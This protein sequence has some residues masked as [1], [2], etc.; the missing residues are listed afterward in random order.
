[1]L[2]AVTDQYDFEFSIRATDRKRQTEDLAHIQEI[3]LILLIIETST[4]I[5][6]LPREFEQ[7]RQPGEIMGRYIF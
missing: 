3:L 5:S 7:Q 2:V 1:M 4:I 6:K